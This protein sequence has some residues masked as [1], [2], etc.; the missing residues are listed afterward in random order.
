MNRWCFPYRPTLGWSDSQPSPETYIPKDR[1]K[2]ETLD[3]YQAR[4]EDEW[5]NKNVFIKVLCKPDTSAR[6]SA[7]RINVKGT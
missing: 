4:K 6:I 3:E 2:D 5:A 1:R 7:S